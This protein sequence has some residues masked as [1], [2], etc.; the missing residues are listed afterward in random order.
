MAKTPEYT[1]RAIDNYRN[2]FDMVQIRLPK[3]TK[4]RI[5]DLTGESCNAYISKLVMESLEKIENK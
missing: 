1:K 2:Q 3:G 4:E 5:K